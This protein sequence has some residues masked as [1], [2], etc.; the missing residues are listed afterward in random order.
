VTLSTGTTQSPSR[1]PGIG[2]GNV[3]TICATLARVRNEGCCSV[4]DPL[5]TNQRVLSSARAISEVTGELEARPDGTV[6][7][8]RCS[9]PKAAGPQFD[10]CG[11]LVALA[12]VLAT[13]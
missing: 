7:E 6:A 1:N 11:A 10:R 2:I 3:E 12:V 13:G 4:A 5:P 8:F 9:A